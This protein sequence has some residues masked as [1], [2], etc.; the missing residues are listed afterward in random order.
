MKRLKRLFTISLITTCM[1]AFI[2]I[3]TNAANAVQTATPDSANSIS[4]QFLSGPNNGTALDIALSYIKDNATDLGLTTADVSNMVVSD[5]YTSQHNGVTHIYFLQQLNGL[6]IHN[7]IININIASDGSV[8]NLGSRFIPDVANAVVSNEV[9][10]SAIEAVVRVAAEL[11]LDLAAQPQIQETIGGSAQRVILDDA[12]I[13]QEP[14]PVQLMYQ[15]T[16]SG[17]Y[18]AWDMTINELSSQHWWSIR[19]NAADGRILSQHDWVVHENAH[20]D[21]DIPA[22]RIPIE[23]AETSQNLLW[24]S[25]E[26]VPESYRVFA[27]PLENPDDGP[28]TL[29]LNPFDITSNPFGWHDTNGLAGAEF[30]ITRGN[31]VYADSDLDANNIPDG[32]APDGGAGLVF[33]HPYFLDMD[34]STYLTAS[35]VNLFYWNNIM[36]DITYLYGFDEPAGNFQE[37]NYG[38]ASIDGDSVLAD[39]Q[40][41]SGTN[42]ANFAT[43]PNGFN[44]RMQ[45]FRTTNP[46]GQAITISTPITLSGVYTANPSNNGGTA[47]GITA[48]IE[49][50]IDNNA[51]IN[52]ACQPLTNNLTGKIALIIW[53]QGACNS[54]VFVQ[55]AA[56]A[57]AVAA[58]IIDNTALPLTNFGGSLSIPSVAIGANDG[59]LFLTALNNHTLNGT[60]GDHPMPGVDRDTSLDNG[61]IA[62]EYGHGVS[63][64][65]TGGPNNVSCLGNAEQMGEGWSDLQT[66]FIHADPADQ[67]TDPREVGVWSLG[68]GHQGIRLFPYSTD[69]NVNPQTYD[70]IKTNGTSPHS[71]GEVWAAMV[72]EVYWNLVDKHGFNPNIYGDWT[73]GGNNLTFQVVMDGLKLQPCSPGFVDGRDAILAADMVLTGG[74]N[75]C[76]IWEGFA[77]RGLGLSANQ[78]SPHSRFDGVEAFDVPMACAIPDAVLSAS[79]SPD[80]VQIGTLLAYELVVSN[81]GYTTATNVVL[82]DVLDANTDFASASSTQGSCSES[83]GTVT[84]NLNSLAVGNMITVTVNVTPTLAGTVTNTVSVAINEPE[85]SNSNNTAVVTT[86]VE[87]NTFYIYMPA[88]LKP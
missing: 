25:A 69:M 63:N 80:P 3:L 43:P 36:H 12:G 59:Q 71:V 60:I 84:C 49:L 19:A 87:D 38:T 86:T 16:N 17:V 40:D 39:A 15:P 5:Q 74:A 45:M 88:A 81:S 6:P 51:P 85:V 52:D 44:P 7:A 41:G 68:A 73:T 29:E 48:D 76:E 53:N 83:G 79:A 24:N 35:I 61:V 42:N 8:I 65:L 77:K 66:L 22:A 26:S 23:T 72:W 11:G 14:I 13:S 33:D 4:G 58:I 54:A 78:G 75:Q 82:T 62:H 1:M 70:S 57:G 2:F 37:Y 28:D 34:P 31:N 46:F 50:V 9:S 47:N 56:N 21:S 18:L 20:Q 30:T 32:N 55:N 64:R 10:V 67:P 27:Y